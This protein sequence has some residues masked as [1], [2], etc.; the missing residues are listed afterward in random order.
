MSRGGQRAPAFWSSFTLTL[1]PAGPGEGERRPAA[2]IGQV[3]VRPGLD[4]GSERLGVAGAAIAED[5]R[6]DE[7]RSSP[8]C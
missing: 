5:D 8:G 6:L 4:Q 1:V 2:S 3:N 7:Q